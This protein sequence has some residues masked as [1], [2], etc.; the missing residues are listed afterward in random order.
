MG[1]RRTY[2]LVQNTSGGENGIEFFSNLVS[3][4]KQLESDWKKAFFLTIGFFGIQVVWTVEMGYG[5]PYLLELG[6]SKTIVS[7][8]WL[9]GP[10]SGLIMQPLI[11]AL[12]DKSTSP[13]GKRRP[14][15]AGTT[16]ITLFSLIII[17]WAPQISN[18]FTKNNSGKISPNSAGPIAVLGFYILDFGI[19]GTMA[20]LRALVVDTLPRDKQSIG[21]AWASCMIGTGNILGFII[22][23]Y[24]LTKNMSAL[25]VTQIQGFILLSAIILAVTITTTCVAIKEVPQ[26]KI[27]GGISKRFAFIS[28]FKFLFTTMRKIPKRIMSVCIIQF[29]SW[30]GWFPFLF[31]VSSFIAG[32][33]LSTSVGNP[34]EK[35][36][37]REDAVRIGSFVL[38]LNSVL[39]IFCSLV[40]PLIFKKSKIAN[41]IYKNGEGMESRRSKISWITQKLFLNYRIE[42]LWMVSNI[43][44]FLCT[45]STIFLK[46]NFVLVCIP[47]ILIGFCWAVSMWVPFTIIGEVL[48]EP[49]SFTENVEQ[50]QMEEQRQLS[51]SKNKNESDIN[52]NVNFNEID[53][54]LNNS[55]SSETNFSETQT[56]KYISLRNVGKTRSE[57]LSPEGLESPGDTGQNSF[58]NEMGTRL[59]SSPG[60]DS[61]GEQ[62]EGGQKVDPGGG[63]DHVADLIGSS[64]SIGHAFQICGVFSL[65]SAFLF[66]RLKMASGFGYSGQNRC[67]TFFQDFEKCYLLAPQDNKSE[68][69]LKKE[70]YMECLH[71]Y[72]EEAKVRIIQTT[73]RRNYQ[74]SGTMGGSS[75]IINLDPDSST[76]S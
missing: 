22:G 70:D 53:K 66:Y 14:F 61:G 4:E 48:S 18:M 3:T 60:S 69:L 5:T 71:H 9:A 74:K 16:I 13:Y 8:V 51:T 15:I 43:L 33:Y 54:S 64:T 26:K 50:Y 25:S 42:N 7:M 45:I 47:I 58:G 29:F 35:T 2:S 21:S 27:N 24:D 30:I 38:F 63:T 12:S 1:G 73:E 72:K 46:T 56:S 41:S 57:T 36:S 20:C 62:E 6:L 40:L 11:G 49:N 39:S 17:G 55:P 65:V 37:S 44:F 31:Y 52:L 28:I 67:F 34:T 59:I 68:C 19:N 76:N 10:I 32:L 75:K 23:Y